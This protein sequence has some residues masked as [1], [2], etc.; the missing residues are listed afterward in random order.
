[1]FNA[2][3]VLLS[4]AFAI[5]TSRFSRQNLCQFVYFSLC[6]TLIIVLVTQSLGK[7]E[8]DNDAIAITM[9]SS[10]LGWIIGTTLVWRRLSLK[11]CLM[12]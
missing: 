3:V 9:A 11:Q 2:K 7:Y 5:V 8:R 1:M 12:H 4:M 10:I 6:W